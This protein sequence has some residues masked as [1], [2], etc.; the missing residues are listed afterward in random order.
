MRDNDKS[1]NYARRGVR[2][3]FSII[4]FTRRYPEGNMDFLRPS[5]SVL[6]ALRCHVNN[7]RCKFSFSRVRQARMHWCVR[8]RL[9]RA[10]YLPS[11]ATMVLVRMSYQTK[12]YRGLERIGD[13][14]QGSLSHGPWETSALIPL[15]NFSLSQRQAAASTFQLLLS[16][17]PVATVPTTGDSL[18]CVR[19]NCQFF[20]ALASL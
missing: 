2:N 5:D 9:H 16:L 6:T 11:G 1:A 12:P 10:S 8:W 18:F 14:L 13:C 7:D 17:F 15:H 3:Q 20:Y 19:S 4:W